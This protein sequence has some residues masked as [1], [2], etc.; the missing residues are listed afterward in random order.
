M[1]GELEI[2]MVTARCQFTFVQKLTSFVS[3]KLY[4]EETN[5]LT[6]YVKIH[7]EIKIYYF[8]T[9]YPFVILLQDLYILCQ[10]FRADHSY[11]SLSHQTKRL[12]KLT[13]SHGGEKVFAIVCYRKWLSL[14]KICF[15][16]KV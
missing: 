1:Q 8:E 13:K 4:H 3:T 10:T 14:K 12:T 16:N 7:I 15:E 2:L 6:F 11:I 9:M 5:S